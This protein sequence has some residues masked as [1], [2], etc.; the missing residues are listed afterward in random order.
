MKVQFIGSITIGWYIA[1]ESLSILENGGLIGVKYPK[2][3]KKAL[4][5]LYNE[6]EETK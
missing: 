2:R 5:I 1:A 6:E 3:L 4:D